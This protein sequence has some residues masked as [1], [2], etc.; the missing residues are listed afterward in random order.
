MKREDLFIVTK[1]PP[2][3]MNPSAV[4]PTVEQSLKNLC[5]DY[6]DL[7]LI[8]SP[9]GIEFDFKKM[10]PIKN[11]KDEH[12]LTLDTDHIGVWREMEK[13]VDEGK[14]RSIGVSNFSSLQVANIMK[15]CR[16]PVAVNQVECSLYF[17]QKKLREKLAKMGI[18]LMAYGSLGSSGM[19]AVLLVSNVS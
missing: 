11:D 15:Q 6:L 1:L 13:L 19:Y 10:A 8:H 14:I 2:F 18:K 16:I 5:I 17:Q 7:Y 4:R 9:M 3:S 12:I